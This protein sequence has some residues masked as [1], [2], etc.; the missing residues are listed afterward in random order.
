VVGAQEEPMGIVTLDDVLK[1]LANGMKLLVDS[2]DTSLKDDRVRRP[3]ASQCMR[4]ATPDR[5]R[6]SANGL[7]ISSL[8]GCTS[9]L[10][11]YCRG[12]GRNTLRP[13]CMTSER[14]A[15]LPI[16]GHWIVPVAENFA[17]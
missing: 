16:D 17:I 9:L 14:S 13:T 1:I 6:S 7:D 2:I 5:P 12:F 3:L 11:T 15:L 8:A 4:I 10:Q